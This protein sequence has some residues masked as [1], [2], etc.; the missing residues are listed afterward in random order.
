[1]KTFSCT[2]HP[3]DRAQAG[4]GAP[5]RAPPGR[6]RGALLDVGRVGGQ[7]NH[8]GEAVKGAGEPGEGERNIQI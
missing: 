4:L 7:D 3:D 1:M 5:H 2:D 6:A 8:A